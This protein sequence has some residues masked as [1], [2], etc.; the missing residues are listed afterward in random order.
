[1]TGDT[2][3]K[4]FKLK[5]WLTI[6]E[7]AKHLAGVLS[8]SV[9]EADVLRLA[10]DGRLKLSVNFV[11]HAD[12]KI[13]RI[14][15]ISEA[16]RIRGIS[17]KSKFGHHQFQG[18]LLNNEE[19]LE[20]DDVTVPLIGVFDLP[21]LGGDR[22]DVEQAYQMA[23]NGPSVTHQEPHGTFVLDAK[24]RYCQVQK[25]MDDFDSPVS[26]TP[27]PGVK[28]IQ[29][30]FDLETDQGAGTK[31]RPIWHEILI[32]QSA[33]DY[34]HP[35]AS[36]PRDS[37]LVV[38]TDA[39]TD[40]L[41]SVDGTPSTMEKPPDDPDNEGVAGDNFDPADLP[42]E[43]YMANLAFRAVTNGHGKQSD[44]FRNR[45]ISYLK[46][47]YPNLKND[48]LQRIATVGNPDKS[49]GRKRRSPE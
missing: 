14:V 31:K 39:L 47:N 29:A 42:D 45:I 26:Y 32:A 43:L 2:V 35:A 16:K 19:V 30:N 33:T 21:L 15:P 11:N 41:K 10:L 12:T 36:L 5:K 17:S 40:F 18:F 34:F 38:R 4:L 23:I 13:G 24:G 22:L 46:L 7:S 27:K 49:T 9:N 28:L 6:E 37:V 48:P 8:E 3:S 1:V 44:T 20:F 25:Y